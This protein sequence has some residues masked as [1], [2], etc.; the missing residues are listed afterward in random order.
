MKG[1]ASPR[2]NPQN[3]LWLVG[4]QGQSFDCVATAAACE[5]LDIEL[6]AE[7][8]ISSRDVKPH[9]PHTPRPRTTTPTISPTLTARLAESPY[10]QSQRAD[11]SQSQYTSRRIDSRCEGGPSRKHEAS[12][13]TVGN[14]SL[15]CSTPSA[16]SGY[17]APCR[18]RRGAP[19]RMS[20]LRSQRHRGS[21]TPSPPLQGETR[22]PTLEGPCPESCED[23]G[24]PRGHNRFPRP[25]PGQRLVSEVRGQVAPRRPSPEAES[26]PQSPFLVGAPSNGIDQAD[27]SPEESPRSAVED[28]HDKVR[29]VFGWDD[30]EFNAYRKKDVWV[31]LKEEQRRR[32]KERHLIMRKMGKLPFGPW[33]KKKEEEA[34]AHEMKRAAAA[35]ASKLL[36]AEKEAAKGVG[37][38]MTKRS[39]QQPA[40]N[41]GATAIAGLGGLGF[42]SMMKNRSSDPA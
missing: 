42:G 40:V 9:A 37:N 27:Q 30:S 31:D 21:W 15:L 13:T 25:K 8:L 5:D 19:P 6:E 28:V 22:S 2:S 33:L 39:A 41:A 36:K 4:M 35:E 1:S 34:K 16:P 12:Y 10:R 7:D 3:V 29:R 23:I 11:S 18:S 20:E 17:R 14:R 38:F 32:W 24:S 26:P